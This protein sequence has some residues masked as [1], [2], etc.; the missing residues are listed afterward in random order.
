M[1][2][3]SFKN[4]GIFLDGLSKFLVQRIRDESHRFAL[5]ANRR[6]RLKQVTKSQLDEISG[7]GYKT[8]VKLLKTF[9]S[10]KNLIKILKTNPELVENLI[11]KKL[12]QKLKNKFC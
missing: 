8:K 10:V 1:S 3:N 9:N 7:I 6:A 2:E 11:G 4:K 12:T 5:Q